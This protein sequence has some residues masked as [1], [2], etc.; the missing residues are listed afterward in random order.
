MG[1]EM[2]A[3]KDCNCMDRIDFLAFFC[4]AMFLALGFTIYGNKAKSWQKA[5][6]VCNGKVLEVY[7]ADIGDTTV[8]YEEQLLKL[9]KDC[10]VWDEE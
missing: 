9:N 2:M 8:V 1:V 3:K 4:I 10:Y 6:I 7:E 5:N